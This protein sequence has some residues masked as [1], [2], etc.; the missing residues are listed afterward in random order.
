MDLEVSAATAS[1]LGR[2]DLLIQMSRTTYV[3]E[4]KLDSSPEAGLKQIRKQQYDRPYLGQGKSIARVGLSFSSE[5]GNIGTWQG[6]LLRREANIHHYD[7]FPLMSVYLTI[8]LTQDLFHGHSSL[9][10]HFELKNIKH[11]G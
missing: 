1:S 4:L 10:V 3:I 2:L 6:E 5:E 9:L 7:L 8:F 11:R